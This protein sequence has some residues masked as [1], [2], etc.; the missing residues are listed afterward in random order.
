MEDCL[1]HIETLADSLAATQSPI[2]NTEL[3]QFGTSSLPPNYRGF[4]TTYSI[5]PDTHTFDDSL[6]KLIFVSND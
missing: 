5:L 3:I 2:S 1:Q 6:C 4:V